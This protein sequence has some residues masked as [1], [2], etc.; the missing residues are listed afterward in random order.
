M[1]PRRIL[2]LLRQPPYATS[3]ALEA[4]EA[5]L[6]AGVFD[7]AVSVLFAD[8][9]VWQLLRDQDGD[10]VGM[11]TVGRVATALPRYD[12][13]DIYV[14]GESLRR[15]GLSPDDLVLPVTLLDG[16]GQQALIAGQHA[17]VSD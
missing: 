4:L 8:D 9:G 2:F 16:A 6:V 17:V 11:R 1:A 7:Q 12:V 3:H 5:V 15:L 14:C 13:N 10:A